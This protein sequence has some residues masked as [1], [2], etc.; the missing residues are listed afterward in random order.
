MFLN[1]VTRCSACFSARSFGPNF[2]AGVVDALHISGCRAG[3]NIETKGGP[4]ILLPDTSIPQ[5][6]R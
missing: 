2:G 5:S 4:S 6:S 1:V 3:E